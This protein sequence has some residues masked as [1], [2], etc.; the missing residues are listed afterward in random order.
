MTDKNNEL[1]LR[2]ETVIPGGVNSPVRSFR[3]V[4]GHPYFVEKAEGAYVCDADGRKYIDYVQSDWEVRNAGYDCA[5]GYMTM[6]N[7]ILARRNSYA[8][9]PV[10][11][12]ASE[13]PI[14][15]AKDAVDV[16]LSYLTA[17]TTDDRV[18]IRA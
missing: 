16:F 9:T 6:L 18:A 17:H 8:D 15:A 5:Y 13:Q 3:S 11:W 2:A 10:L 4:G 12:T 7:Y 1:R 14:T